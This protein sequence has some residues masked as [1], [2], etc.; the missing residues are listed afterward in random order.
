[1]LSLGK[2]EDGAGYYYT[3]FG[4]ILEH[5][6]EEKDLGVIIDAEMSFENHINA[7]V[8]KANQMMGLIRRVFSYLSKD[9]FLRLYTSF[10][11]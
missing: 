8:K 9:M 4:Q 3:L 5:I 6:E 10:V 2:F 7:K 1:M 11:R